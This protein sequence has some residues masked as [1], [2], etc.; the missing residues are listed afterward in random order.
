MALRLKS[1]FERATFMIRMIENAYVA[2]TKTKWI[3]DV[4][5]KVLHR[6]DVFQNKAIASREDGTM[7]VSGFCTNS[8]CNFVIKLQRIKGKEQSRYF[9]N[10]V[11]MQKLFADVMLAPPI[12]KYAITKVHDKV[13]GT[14]LMERVETITDALVRPNSRWTPTRL[15]REFEKLV[16]KLCQHDIAHGDLHM[17]NLAINSK[18]QLFTIDMGWSS[19][20][21]CRPE[22]EWIQFLRGV[23]MDIADGKLDDYTK[24]IYVELRE[25]IARHLAKYYRLPLKYPVSLDEVNTLFMTQHKDYE[26]SFYDQVDKIKVN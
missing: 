10:E 21:R 3:G 9:L 25:E 13:F 14:I 23:L 22:L 17:G 11:N 8:G 26:S 6:D 2:N 15:V 7:Y 24:S 20:Y 4:L 1:D 5:K 12:I 19:Q 18:G 16:K